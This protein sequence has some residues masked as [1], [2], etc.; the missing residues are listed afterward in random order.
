MDGRSTRGGSI[1]RTPDP[2]R[3]KG[4]SAVRSRADHRRVAA[5]FGSPSGG[6]VRT[7]PVDGSTATG[8]GVRSATRLP[9]LTTRSNGLPAAADDVLEAAA[10]P[11]PS[12]SIATAG[13]LPSTTVT[14]CTAEASRPGRAG[15]DAV[16]R[17]AQEPTPRLM[18]AVLLAP[19]AAGSKL[20]S[21]EATPPVTFAAA[22]AK[23]G[24]ARPSGSAV[25]LA[26]KTTGAAL[27]ARREPEPAKAARSGLTG[28]HT[29]VAKDEARPVRT[30]VT[31]TR[32]R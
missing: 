4:S 18:L 32:A 8:L 28:T 5:R 19:G 3:L 6:T 12:T 16:T 22:Q 7:L 24:A 30:A 1:V 29:P 10:A 17:T 9:S 25:G 26:S 23:T 20:A 15:S 21:A 14:S 11:A 2:R 31:F 27:P 13:S